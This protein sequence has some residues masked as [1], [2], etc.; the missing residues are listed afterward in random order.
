MATYPIPI[1]LTAETHQAVSDLKAKT[2]QT[3]SHILREAVDAGLPIVAA[4]LIPTRRTS[5]A[6][7]SAARRSTPRK[8][9]EAA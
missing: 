2:N 9:K 8:R 6:T 5:A 3:T 7:D 4:R 1:R